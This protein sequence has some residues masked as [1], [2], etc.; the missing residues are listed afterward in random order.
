MN[1]LESVETLPHEP[2]AIL[3]GDFILFLFGRL[4]SIIGQ[5]MSIVAVGWVFAILLG[6][7]VALVPVYAKDIHQRL[8]ADD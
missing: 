7:A 1:V 2:Y 8:D 4:V 5:Q 6:G 3:S